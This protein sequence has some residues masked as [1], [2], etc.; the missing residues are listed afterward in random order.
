[1]ERIQ[2]LDDPR[3][4]AYRNLPD[5]TLRGECVFLAEGKL[6][7]ERL[8]ESRYEVES[9][10]VST[11]YYEEFRR[12]TPAGVPLYAAEESLLLAIVGF[13]FHRG[14]LAVGRRGRPTTL[15]ELLAPADREV[16]FRLAVCPEITKPENM[17][18]IFRNAAAFGL[19]GILLGER[20]CDPFSR[21]SMRVSMGAVL[22]MPFY[23]SDNLNESLKILKDGSDFSLFAAV[24]DPLARKLDEV[25]WPA[26][27]GILLGNEMDGLDSATLELCDH[28]V[29]IPITERVD[30]LNLG[31]AAG[32][33]F[34]SM[35]RRLFS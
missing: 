9:V 20:C 15:A 14:A 4:A 26:R 31:V 35:Q 1:M 19:S 33:C 29:T 10:F 27:C 17:G 7:T 12:L 34:Y 2:S 21:R 5:R 11:D 13:P 24:L 3:V 8:L 28:R 22:Q 32:I 30:S 25:D 23:K 16:Q 6:L 18:L